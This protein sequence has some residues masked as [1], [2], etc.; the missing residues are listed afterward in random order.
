MLPSRILESDMT[1]W[2]SLSTV[3]GKEAILH[4]VVFELR[5]RYGMTYLDRC[6]RTI[7]AIMKDHPEWTLLS[8]HPN[9][10]AAPL[11]SLANSC[12]FHFSGRK[13]D[14]ALER[15]IGEDP[16]GPDDIKRFADQTEVVTAVVLDQLAL[17]EF[18]RMGFRAW[19]LFPGTS[20]QDSE[21]WLQE[22]GCYSTSDELTRAFGGQI[23]AVSVAVVVAADDRKY[24]VA[25]S[26]VERQAQLK[27]GEGI[28][29]V[30]ARDLHE[31]QRAFLLEQQRVKA[32][33]HRSPEHAAMIDVDA[34]AEEPAV[35]EPR[36]FIETSYAGIVENLRQI[37][38][39]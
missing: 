19:Y 13:L 11:V 33:M 31:N 9:P 29:N 4:K 1:T 14:L 39:K 15:P 12:Q 22:L 16:L 24:R 2:P 7:N 37:L 32:R 30:R 23:E 27:I 6:G 8:D 5:Y 25:F 3:R 18:S 28:L 20:Q 34:Y 38:A 17:E 35:V 21:Q 10:Q 26:G 36:R